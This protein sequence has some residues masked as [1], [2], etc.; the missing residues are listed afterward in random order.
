MSDTVLRYR[1]PVTGDWREL[2]VGAGGPSGPVGPPGPPGNP[3]PIGPAGP[4]TGVWVQ[5]EPPPAP[6]AVPPRPLMLWVDTDAEGT[7]GPWLTLEEGDERYVNRAGGTMIGPLALPGDPVEPLHAAAKQYVDETPWFTYLE[8]KQEVP[9]GGIGSAIPYTPCTITLGPGVWI[10]QA[11]AFIRQDHVLD[12]VWV[13]VAEINIGL[14]A[15]TAGAA[16]APHVGHHEQIASAQTVLTV[17]A[18]TTRQFCPYAWPNG[19]S[20]IIVPGTVNGP[21]ATMSAIRIARR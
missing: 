4:P 18:G 6:D 13:G 2:S 20:R 8:S 12:A 16:G 17:P 5:P 10:V 14:L 3:G 9:S 21:T 1:D 15:N 19:E 7:D 11:Q